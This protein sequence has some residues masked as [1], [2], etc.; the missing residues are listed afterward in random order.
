MLARKPPM[1]V[2]VA[3]ANKMARIVWALLAKG[4]VYRAP[5]AAVYAPSRPRG[6]RGGGRVTGEGW[7]NGRETGSGKPASRQ[8][9]QA[10]VPE[11][12]LIHGLPS[13]PAACEPHQRPHTCQHST[14]G[15]TAPEDF[16]CS[17]RG[18]H[19]CREKVWPSDAGTPRLHLRFVAR[20]EANPAQR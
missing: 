7:R 8:A 2:R 9:L 11:L 10:R 20:N 12:D 5:V 3:L 13:G 15:H 4:G 6:C 19:T 17:S 16:S 14:T 1:L 18:V